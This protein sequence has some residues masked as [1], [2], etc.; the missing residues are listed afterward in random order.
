MYGDQVVGHLYSRGAD[1]PWVI[2]RFEPAEGWLQVKHLFAAQ[3]E[4]RRLGFPEDKV[5]AVKAVRDLGLELQ[6]VS[7]GAVINPLLL[8]IDGSDA[9]FRY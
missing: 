4:A 3:A 6:H 8:Y 5:W 1:Q 2:C 9:Q 7:N